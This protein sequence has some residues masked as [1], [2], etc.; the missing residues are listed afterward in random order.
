MMLVAVLGAMVGVILALTGAGGGILAVPLLVFGVHLS[1]A[2]AGPIGLLAVGMAATLGTLLGLRAKIVRYKAAMLI[3]LSGMLLAPLG[4]WLAQ[5]L[6]NRPLSFLFAL[7]LFWV[8]YRSWQQARGEQARGE[9]VH[10]EGQVCHEAGDLPCR[11]NPA[12]GRFIWTFATARVFVAVGAVAGLLSGLLGVGGG[13]VLVPVMRR[14]TDLSMQSIVSTSM[15]V[16]ALLSGFN[17]LASS[18]VGQL[19][20]QIGAPFSLGAVLGMLGARWFGQRL[21]GAWLSRAFAL[22]TAAVA[23]GLLVKVWL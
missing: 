20:W 14:Y 8:A 10:G 9:Q 18:L 2:K 15:A 5:R 1:M 11:I 4:L 16:I 13:F 6:P 19:D 12:T 22:V 21:A 17:V 3:A 7:V 23:I